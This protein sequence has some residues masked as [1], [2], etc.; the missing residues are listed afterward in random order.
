MSATGDA[1]NV[2][3]VDYHQRVCCVSTPIESDPGRYYVYAV[4]RAARHKEGRA[5]APR[6]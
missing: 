5:R 4:A 6:P 2:D 3:L 1:I